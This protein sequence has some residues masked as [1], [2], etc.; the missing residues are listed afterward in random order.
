M[1]EG[2]YT[3]FD[4]DY[5]N[6]LNLVGFDSVDEVMK[7][8]GQTD[9]LIGLHSPHPL[10]TGVLFS[11][12]MPSDREYIFNIDVLREL[13]PLAQQ[14]GF[15]AAPLEQGVQAY[16]RTG[17]DKLAKMR[18]AILKQSAFDDPKELDFSL[19]RLQRLQFVEFQQNKDERLNRY[20]FKDPQNPRRSY[21]VSSQQLRGWLKEAGDDKKLIPEFVKAQEKTNRELATAVVI[22]CGVV[23][24][25]GAGLHSWFKKNHDEA[26]QRPFNPDEVVSNRATGRYLVNPMQGTVADGPL[27]STPNEAVVVYDVQNMRQKTV[28]MDNAG[29]YQETSSELVTDYQKLGQ[30]VAAWNRVQGQGEVN[31]ARLTEIFAREAKLATELQE[32]RVAVKSAVAPTP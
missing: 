4:P 17:G 9:L 10:A 28:S 5:I 23:I 31:A 8:H 18:H 1:S 30:V 25:A 16:E 14:H 7:R 12:P 11:A 6:L 27:P 13:I 19:A 15:D 24:A 3:S 21:E 20:I 26:V 32:A 22:F 29:D 2:T